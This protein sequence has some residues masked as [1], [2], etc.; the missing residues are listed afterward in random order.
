MPA[1]DRLPATSG[2]VSLLPSSE[3]VKIIFCN[4]KSMS[5]TA[6]RCP[7]NEMHLKDSEPVGIETQVAV[8]VTT[9]E[10][11]PFCAFANNPRESDRTIWAARMA[12]R[13]GNIG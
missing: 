4:C 5:A 6:Y 9:P 3:T 2:N 10:G 12:G 1:R 11:C 8:P 13:N 7:E